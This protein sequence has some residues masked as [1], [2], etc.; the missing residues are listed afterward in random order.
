MDVKTYEND[1]RSY[2]KILNDV[3]N[4]S[5]YTSFVGIIV[6]YFI[7]NIRKSKIKEVQRVST[8]I[9]KDIAMKY[10][11]KLPPIILAFATVLAS[12]YVVSECLKASEKEL[13]ELGDRILGV[14]LNIQ[15][16]VTED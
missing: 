13:N 1:V 4:L 10:G 2:I 6:D 3:Q 14:N 9:A 11:S 12:Q 8:E 16:D 5:V 15:I 7:N